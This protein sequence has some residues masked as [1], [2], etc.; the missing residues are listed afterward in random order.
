MVVNSL[1]LNF[2]WKSFFLRCPE[3]KIVVK[4]NVSLYVCLCRRVDLELSASAKCTRYPPRSVIGSH[5]LTAYHS[6][7]IPLKWLVG[8]LGGERGRWSSMSVGIIVWNTPFL[9]G[10]VRLSRDA[11]NTSFN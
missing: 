6:L 5:F 4:R 3:P 2:Q 1:I 7:Q 11:V 9:E 8:Q 10:V